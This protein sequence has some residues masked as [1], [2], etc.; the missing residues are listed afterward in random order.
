MAADLGRSVLTGHVPPPVKVLNP[1]SKLPGTNELQLAISLPVPNEA[2]LDGLLQQLYDPGSTNFHK[3]LTPVEFAA[4]FGP[5]E[6]DYQNLIAFAQTNGL[7]IVGTYPNRLVLSVSG[8]VTAVEGAFQVALHTYP[9]P[10][11]AR[12]FYAP[13]REPSVPGNLKVLSIEGLSDYSRPRHAGLKTM[14]VA[15]RPAA[16]EGSGPNGEYAGNDFRNAYVP[17]SALTGTGQSVALLEFSDYYPVD[18]TNYENTIGTLNGQ[19]NYVPLV[20]KV[21][22]RTPSRTSN[23][24]VA[25]DIEMVLS[26]APGISNVYVY[27]SRTV[28]SSLLNQIATDNL[29]KQVSSSWTVGSWSTTLAQS[30]DNILK[31]MA[32]Q[33]QSYF[34]ASS[35]S[36]A[37]TGSHLLDSGTSVPADSPYAT[38]VGGT[39]LSMS[40]SAW[41]SET[42]WNYNTD[43]IP[44][45]GSGGGISAYY[46]QPYWQTNISMAANSGST[47]FRN[48]P[49]VA[50]TA[51]NIFISYND[52][53][54][55]GSSYAMGT[56]AAA[57]LWAGFCALANQLA[58]ATNGTPLGFLNPAL[59]NLASSGTYARSYHD[60]T[61]GNNIGT[62]TPGYYYAVAGY[63][64]CTGL[65]TPAG[66]NLINALVWPPPTITNQPASRTVVSGA[67]VTLTGGASSTTQP[68]FFW[69]CNGTN[70]AS[71][72]NVSGASTSA[73]TI[74]A[75][76]AN[77]AGSYQLVVSN[78]TGSV[79][80]IV[81]VL[82]IGLAPTV[83][84]APASQIL[85]AGS[86]A[87]FTANADGTAPL[88]Y[89]WQMSGTNFAGPGISGTNSS[90]LTLGAVTA[91]STANYTVVVT[92][93]YGSVT[94]SV[95]SLTVVLPPSIAGSSVTNQT[96]QCG[97]NRLAFTVSATGTAPLSY[98]WSFDGAAVAAATNAT[99]LLTNLHLPS[100]TVSVQVTNLYASLITNAVI[101]VQDTL[102]PVITLKGSNPLTLELGNAFVDPGATATDLCAGAV[103]VLVSGSVNLNAVS[104]NT[105]IYSAT[106]GNGNT[107]TAARTVFVRDTTPPAI[108][109]SF[110]NLVLA[111]NASCVA[112]LPDVTGT[113]YLLAT[114]LSGIAAVTESPTNGTILGL[115]TNEVVL[116]V[117]DPY[118]NTAFSTNTI[119]VQDQTPPVIT[120]NGGNPL[121]VE[122]GAVFT[123]PGVTASDA[124]SG[125][126]LLVTNGTVNVNAVG[127]NLLTY[128][129][130]D[131][132]GNTNCVT[133]TVYVQDTTPPTITW[134]FTNLVLAATSNCVA[135]LPEVTGTNYLLA[136]D[137]SGIAA[138]TESPTN[139]AILGLGT[140][141][142]V[143]A[144]ADPYGNTAFSTNTI[145][146]QD[147][148][149]P[150]ILLEPQSQTN[151]AG[152]AVS[153]SVAATACTPLS[154]QWY[155]NLVALAA[156]TNETLVVSNLSPA[157]VGD[158]VV[159]VS[160]AGGS[161]ASAMA[162]L[163]LSVPSAISSVSVQFGGVVLALSGEPGSTYVLEGSTNLADPLSWLPIATNALGADGLWQ[164]TDFSA[165]NS[166]E[167]YY[168]LRLAPGP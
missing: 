145:V 152:A 120:L 156:Q 17:G 110:T 116:A 164:F 27:E 118:G 16:S 74:T 143:L 48:I 2:E 129:A 71:G 91:N 61:T 58:V 31:T 13:D 136:T 81:A 149:P 154:Y 82:T 139:G 64:L 11:E 90:V 141:E 55:D 46:P 130:V 88:A 84:V 39:S 113:N 144:V 126:A 132:S 134:S 93:L 85:L 1:K 12:D 111:A 89:R 115:G 33:G 100:H 50:L 104:T 40:G 98:Q 77:N 19:T 135:I 151:D 165:T 73:L 15:A 6:P 86:N 106:D 62:N 59:Y 125:V 42:V 150:V 5:S 76:T 162:A 26:I 102:A 161:S 97:S 44:N 157:V 75:A 101:T 79:T 167:K 68:A 124:C 123:D 21:S 23:L 60:I 127:T 108:T 14:A 78:L 35:D 7:R 51:D 8:P 80:S 142:V 52:G 168:R 54:Y 92:N 103:G 148:T 29:A 94:S 140:N 53:T 138:V 18:I 24:E 72:G 163:T 119:V 9:H 114:D 70:L 57:P 65:G 66:T 159:V 10:T 166:A 37:F 34:Q 25:L 117:A 67:N 56:S 131:G 122:L 146:V 155:F 41:S 137:L 49:D 63:D 99:F 83:A 3:F 96:V 153:F 43:G 128:M 121:L 47:S 87:V 109:W 133:R 36:D 4:H 20:N 69:L 147:Q 32:T 107:N 95:V 160:A 22:G 45:E 38:V 112:T 30:F 28:S 158:Y 105:V